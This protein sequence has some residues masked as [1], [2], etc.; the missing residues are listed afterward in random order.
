MNSYS[1][2][3]YIVRLVICIP[4][5]QPSYL[6]WLM[7]SV[8]IFMFVKGMSLLFESAQFI[9][10]R[11][12]AF[13]PTFQVF[14]VT[15]QRGASQLACVLHNLHLAQCWAVRC[16]CPAAGSRV[17]GARGRVSFSGPCVCSWHSN[18]EVYFYKIGSK[19]LLLKAYITELEI[20][21]KS[22]IHEL[23]FLYSRLLSGQTKEPL[24]IIT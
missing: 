22:Y 1:Y 20:N 3:L 8:W 9:Y 4:L 5:C 23:L 21:C 12:R 13:S 17:E 6:A 10:W 7:S 2:R 11:A 15:Y 16:C 18:R 19:G 24:V 14:Y